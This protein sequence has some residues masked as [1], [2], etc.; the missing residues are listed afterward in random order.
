MGIIKGKY[1]R[2]G[3]TECKKSK[4]KCNECKPVCWNCQRLSKKCTYITPANRVYRN[5]LQENEKFS[6]TSIE[7]FMS[8]EIGIRLSPIT[9][10]LGSNKL[11][12]SDDN[13]VANVGEFPKTSIES[14]NINDDSF[15]MRYLQ[16]F[17]DKFSR[18]LTPFCLND[19]NNDN[20]VINS[21]KDIILYYCRREEYLLLAVLACGALI[22]FKE[23]A[24]KEDENNYFSYLSKCMKLLGEAINQ[25]NKFLSLILTIL[26]LTSFNAS[27]EIINWR[28]HLDIC[29]NLLFNKGENEDL[30][31]IIE[32]ETLSFCR[33]LYL[34]IEIVA[35]E[36]SINGG[37]ITS[38]QEI[39]TI[40]NWILTDLC[41]LINLKLVLQINGSHFNLML[42]QTNELFV[43]L[44]NILN[45]KNTQNEN[46][47]KLSVVVEY[48]NKLL[49]KEFKEFKVISSTGY[50]TESEVG[51]AGNRFVNESYDLINGDQ[52]VSWWDV[53]Y[54]SNRLMGI[55]II[56]H[57]LL[58][59]DT[60]S[61]LF[62]EIIT[63]SLDIIK[64]VKFGLVKEMMKSEYNL[65]MIQYF[66]YLVG[67][68][69]KYEGE[70][71]IVCEYFQLLKQS[72]NFNESAIDRTLDTL[73][74]IWGAA[75][76]SRMTAEGED[77]VLKY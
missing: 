19:V 14:I 12:S 29:K 39:K 77:D 2:L 35:N 13:W 65:L 27:S 47:V 26:I 10:S 53:S 7:D 38:K 30:T 28:P 31:G 40:E 33:N 73:K 8:E 11:T 5:N 56:L 66:V 63:E 21:T 20:G 71:K 24:L 37:T 23:T 44:I 54:Q 6:N 17:T 15:K 45:L 25:G 69:C 36:S 64:F 22:S 48:L 58:K 3:C 18:Y 68:F 51:L 57:E 50:F 60:N 34:S 76:G 41:N 4:I 16:L 67:S 55:I 9:N 74:Q 61:K 32:I 52:Y 72:I 49:G 46:E 42:G 70:Q 62:R 59:M 75:N 43:I 1:S